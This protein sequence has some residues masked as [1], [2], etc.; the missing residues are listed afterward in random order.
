ME[1][2][3]EELLEEVKETPEESQVWGLLLFFAM[4]ETEWRR[5]VC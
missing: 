4:L 1:A 5:Q 2:V 3:V